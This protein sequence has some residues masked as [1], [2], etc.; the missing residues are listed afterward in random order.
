VAKAAKVAPTKIESLEKIMAVTKL[1]ILLV[2]F[3][4][5]ILMRN[6]RYQPD[7]LYS[8]RTRAGH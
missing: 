5:A 1:W 7:L 2:E 8:F 3:T 4:E 6:W